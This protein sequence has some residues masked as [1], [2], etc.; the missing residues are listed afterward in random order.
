MPYVSKRRPRTPDVGMRKVIP[1]WKERLNEAIKLQRE[2]RK[3]INDPRNWRLDGFGRPY[4]V[5]PP[6]SNVPCAPH[7]LALLRARSHPS[8][9]SP[10]K[11]P[12]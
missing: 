3:I 5:N 10:R 9:G 11:P 6:I 7:V 12:S 1:T 2:R 8:K 4:L